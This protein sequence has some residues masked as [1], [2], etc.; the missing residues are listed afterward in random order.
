MIII[1]GFREIVKELGF[2]GYY[3]CNRCNNDGNWQL[4]KE[5]NWFTLFFI[6][7][8]PCGTRYYVYCPICRT[9]IRVPKEEAKRIR[10]NQEA[11][12]MQAQGNLG[13]GR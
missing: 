3:H 12:K 10:E 4:R 7:I 2:V 5:T 11:M 6:P 8:I 1:W 13:V 9:E